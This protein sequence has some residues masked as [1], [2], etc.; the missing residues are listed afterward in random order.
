DPVHA[1]FRQLESMG[2][3]V[4]AVHAVHHARWQLLDCVPLGSLDEVLD[5]LLAFS[6]HTDPGDGRAP[7]V[8]VRIADCAGQMD[9]M[10]PSPSSRATPMHH[11][12]SG[13][14]RVGLIVIELCDHAKPLATEA[15]GPV[16]GLARIA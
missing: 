3:P 12:H 15:I 10:D 9:A 4:M 1:A 16:A 13:S 14:L 6:F 5:S 11:E 7:L 2:W 8:R